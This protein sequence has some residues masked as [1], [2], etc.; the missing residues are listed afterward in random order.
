M[1]KNEYLGIY[2]LKES[3]TFRPTQK[4]RIHL[5]S[6]VSKTMTTRDDSCCVI[7]RERESKM[8]RNCI[9]C[10]HC[11]SIT[12]GT[13][14]EYFCRLS[15]KGINT[16][17]DEYKKFCGYEPINEKGCRLRIRKLT[18]LE[19]FR[20]MG[21]EDQVVEKLKARGLSD[22]QLYHIAGDGLVVAIPQKI[23][24]RMK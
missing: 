6:N 16:L 19:C 12:I 15:N 14:T 8:E 5:N 20:L 22:S 2:D 17:L 11:E 4:H 24:E 9:N 13:Y 23:F 10:K 1:I 18:P 3:D 21:A 7:E